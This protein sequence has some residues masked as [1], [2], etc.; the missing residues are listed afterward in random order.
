MEFVPIRSVAARDAVNIANELLTYDPFS[1]ILN[2][3]DAKQWIKTG[4]ELEIKSL[5]DEERWVK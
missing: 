4:K 2:K 3:V 5:K 1:F